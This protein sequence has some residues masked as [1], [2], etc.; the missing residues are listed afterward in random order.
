MDTLKY[1]DVSTAHIT[2]QDNGKLERLAGAD[3]IGELIVYEYLYGFFIPCVQTLRS[4][5]VSDGMS[6]SFI[7]ICE[8]ALSEKC[9]LI[10][11]DADGDRHS[12]FDEHSW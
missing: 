12:E 9:G 8:A 2:A 4:D 7:K 1:L 6:P 5:A 10:R 3:G 11:I